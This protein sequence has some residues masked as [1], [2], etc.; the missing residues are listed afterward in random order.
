MIAGILFTVAAASSSGAAGG[1][2]KK[3]DATKNLYVAQC[4]MCHGVDGRSPLP[5]MKFVGRPWKT[6]NAAEA[7]RVISEG[8]PG[9]AMLPFEGKLTKEQIR[10]LAAYVRALDTPAARKKKD[11]GQA[12]L[13]K[14]PVPAP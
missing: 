6:K 7:A 12:P 1:Q 9:T 11:R 4:Q 5:D 13:V 10:A 14:V 8:V 2:K 3:I